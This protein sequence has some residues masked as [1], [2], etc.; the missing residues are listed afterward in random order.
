MRCS[1]LA[2]ALVVI[3]TPIFGLPI[4]GSIA[5]RA[6][7]GPPAGPPA[8]SF[9]PSYG[10]NGGS[11]QTG[12]SGS[13]NG[14]SVYQQS[15]PWGYI[16]N[17][18]GSGKSHPAPAPLV[19]YLHNTAAQGGNGG[20]SWTGNAIGGAGGQAYGFDSHGGNGGYASTGNSGSANGGDVTNK[21]GSVINAPYASQGGNGGYT[22]SG[23][24]VG[25]AGGSAVKR[26]P[27]P[28][29]GPP[30]IVFPPSYGGNGGSAQTGSSGSVNGGSVNQQ[31]SPWGY[32]YNGFGSGKF[33][34]AQISLQ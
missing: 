24:A 14:G 9:P 5:K 17:G 3:T 4:D 34:H 32:I 16:Y 22:H 33:N 6:P 28:P 26:E 15:S 29:A 8:V 30:A 21:G 12:S 1:L 10:G 18:F 7:G 25:G 20:Y 2:F 27:S 11:A 13:V 31:A 19:F 23:S